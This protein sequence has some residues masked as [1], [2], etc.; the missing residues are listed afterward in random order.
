MSKPVIFANKLQMVK[1][2]LLDKFSLTKIMFF[3]ISLIY[4]KLKNLWNANFQFGLG[5]I[6]AV[7]SSIHQTLKAIHSTPLNALQ[8]IGRIEHHGIYAA[9]ML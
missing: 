1:N 5:I 3:C 4:A 2:V 9:A 6:D 8:V 7:P